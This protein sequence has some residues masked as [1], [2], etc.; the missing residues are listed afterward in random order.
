MAKKQNVVTCG[1]DRRDAMLKTRDELP[2]SAKQRDTVLKLLRNG[3]TLSEVFT[4]RGL[5]SYGSFYTTRANDPLFDDAVRQALAQGAEAAIAEA[6][7][8][9]RRAAESANPDDMRVAEA[10][11]RCALSYAEKAAPREYGQLIKLGNPDGG[12]LSL[13]VVTYALPAIVGKDQQLL[14]T[15]RARDA[16]EAQYEEL[17]PA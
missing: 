7:E 6:A 12:A 8:M 15:P 13:S 10:F 2:L 16:I 3:A 9:S 5:A 17:D 11:H 1:R 4:M 14:D